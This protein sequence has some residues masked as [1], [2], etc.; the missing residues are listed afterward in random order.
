M[1]QND[2]EAND[3]RSTIDA[4]SATDIIELAYTI[5]LSFSIPAK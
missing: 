2:S 1:K 5:D 3:V 4:R